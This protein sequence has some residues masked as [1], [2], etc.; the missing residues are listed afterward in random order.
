MTGF[1]RCRKSNE[2]IEISVEAKS[3]NGKSL[4]IKYAMPKMFNESTG[5]LN[6]TVRKLV[7]RGNVDIYIDYK[8]PENAAVDLPVNIKR[9]TKY[10]NSIKNLRD[11]SEMDINVSL[12][13]ILSLPGVMENQEVKVSMYEEPLINAVS[14]ALKKLN[15]ERESEG[16]RLKSYLLEHLKVIEESIRK[17]ELQTSYIEKTVKERLNERLSSILKETKDAE[18]II[19]LE[20]ALI[21]EKQDVSEELSRLK[22]HV[23]RFKELSD[24]DE[25][26]GKSLD[27]LCQEM[28]RE[29]NT[30]SNKVSTID[31]TNEVL[32]VKSEIS[33]I[34]EQVQNVE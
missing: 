22:S 19:E 9:V 20:V 3:L 16:K 17:L 24:K 34:K 2:N 21:S 11:T 31:V 10:L 13:D 27:F 25:P 12:S 7:K 18:K 23:K 4:R 15:V 33:K 28:L 14:C 30:L 8:L 6:E 26:V 32:R 29:I 5:K 1:G